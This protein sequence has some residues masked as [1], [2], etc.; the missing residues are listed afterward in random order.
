[1]NQLKLWWRL[2]RGEHAVMSF[3]A[4]VA[5]AIISTSS[6]ST[7]YL[8]FALGPALI[9]LASFIFNDVM[10]LPSDLALGRME[11]PLVSKKISEKTA[12]GL[13]LSLFA[14]GLALCLAA[15]LLA[16]Q[17]AFFYSLISVA[18]SLYLKKLPLLGNAIVSTTYAISFV[19]GNAVAV[20]SFDVGSWNLLVISFAGF[21]FLAG[22]GREVLI[23]LRD[24]KGDKKIGALTLPMVV[25]GKATVMLSAFLLLL[26]I[27]ATFTPLR[28][29]RS[30]NFL[31]Y[32]LFVGVCDALLLYSAISAWRD[33]SPENLVRIRNYTIRAFQL[34]LAGFVAI[35]V[36]TVF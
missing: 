28:V 6:F 12:F 19:Y 25:G 29:F 21:A 27:A 8:F 17:I 1:M 16:F 32:L 18:Y 15:S 30:G 3:V 33:Y 36:I 2:A 24:V 34:A 9:V 31:V 10:D 20:N 4:I 11:R 23:T 5:S 14:A 26:A 13:S 22:L 7:N 35:A